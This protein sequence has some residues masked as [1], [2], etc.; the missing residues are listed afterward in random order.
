MDNFLSPLTKYKQSDSD[1]WGNKNGTPINES[2]CPIMVTTLQ[3]RAP[4]YYSQCTAKPK[5][6]RPVR[7]ARFG[8]DDPSKHEDLM[9]CGR[10]ANAYDRAFDKE[11]AHREERAT[12]KDA[13]ESAE[14][15]CKK[16]AEI[17][18]EAF[19]YYAHSYKGIGHYTG[20]IVVDP[21]ILMEKLDG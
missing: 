15:F 2:R 20:E 6:V 1:R 18:I 4:A 12:N 14:D 21:K 8:F 5:D 3:G 7:T 17:G 9:V 10:H 19:P 11:K 16:L 13:H